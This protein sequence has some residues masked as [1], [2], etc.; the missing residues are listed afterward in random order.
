MYHPKIYALYL[1]PILSVQ[2]LCYVKSVDI[3]MHVI[4]ICR[5]TDQNYDMVVHNSP[6]KLFY[7]SVNTR[8]KNSTTS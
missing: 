5:F 3:I 7:Y 8:Q 1:G 6:L 2:P 4:L